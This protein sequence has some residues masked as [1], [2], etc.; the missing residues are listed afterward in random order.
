[1]AYIGFTSLIKKKTE[2]VT[3]EEETRCT[4]FAKN[5]P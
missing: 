4:F 3:A 1:M 2:S 5:S